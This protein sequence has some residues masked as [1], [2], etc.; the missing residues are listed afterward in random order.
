MEQ[1]HIKFQYTPVGSHHHNI[2]KKAIQIFKNHF[3]AGLCSLPPDFQ[4]NLWDKILLQ[5]EITPNLLWPPQINPRL[6]VYVQVHGAFDYNKTPLTPPGCP[7]QVYIFPAD[8]KTFDQHT[9]AGFY[10]GPALHHYQCHGIW[11]TKSNAE[12]TVQELKCFSDI[13]LKMPVPFQEAII[14]RAI[15]IFLNEIKSRENHKDILPPE[16]Q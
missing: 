4:M 11:M 16:N 1:Q 3:V 12:R 2:D 15:Q 14:I 8:R 13:N 10:F 5:A 6:S 7:V 9:K